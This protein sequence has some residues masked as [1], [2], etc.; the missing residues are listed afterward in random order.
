MYE[1]YVDVF[2]IESNDMISIYQFYLT[3][4][5]RI[6]VLCP[7]LAMSRKIIILCC[8]S[9]KGVPMEAV[10]IKSTCAC[11]GIRHC[12]LCEDPHSQR[13]QSSLAA[14][15]VARYCVRNICGLPIMSKQI[16]SSCYACLKLS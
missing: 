4:V 7:A 5:C 2:D 6:R 8:L 3:F 11:K 9:T 14:A 12:L 13:N 15:K 10:N 1:I 16:E